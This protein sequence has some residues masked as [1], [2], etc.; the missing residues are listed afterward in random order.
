MKYIDSG[1]T[2][3]C[4]LHLHDLGMEDCEP[5]RGFEAEFS[6]DNIL[7]DDSESSSVLGTVTG[8][9]CWQCLNSRVADTGDALSA[10][11]H[12]IAFAAQKIL[13]D[14]PWDDTIIEDAVLIDRIAISPEFRGQGFLPL[15]IEELVSFLR[16]D[17]NGCIL[18][19]QPEPQKPEGG[20]YRVGEIRDRAKTGLCRS[21]QA[22]GFSPWNEGPKVW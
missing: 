3:Q 4:S 16:P 17:V 6:L 12:Y 19:T 5:L 14:L 11:A 20:P 13:E 18:V 10:D 9:A 15:M 21:L 1:T 2:L 7:D 8:W 22:A